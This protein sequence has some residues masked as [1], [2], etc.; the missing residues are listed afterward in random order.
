MSTAAALDLRVD[1]AVI[2]QESNR[3][4]V[5]L[6]PCDVLARVA[7]ASQRAVAELEVD[8][9]RLL[10]T[11]G[12][13]VALLDPRVE[14]RAY[15]RD[16]FVVTLW[17][18]YEPASSGAVAPAEYAR[19]LRKV[20]T[21]M[22][23]L[24]LPVPHCTD[25]V[26]TAREL[27]EDRDRTPDL[28]D[29]DR[30]LLAGTLATL[31]R[32]IGPGSGAQQLLHGEPHPG[33]V[34]RTEAGLLFVDLETCCRGPVEFDVAHVPDE[35][36]ACYPG[37]DPDLLGRCRL[38]VHAMVAAWRW[39]REDRFPDGRRMGIECLRQLRERRDRGGAEWIV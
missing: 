27:V 33:N 1:E 24:D 28:G 21:S 22:A 8:I 25:R 35:V 34:L 37:T 17:T 6:R 13:P 14:P 38:L 30:E 31:G 18:F 11:T 16:G 20:H 39:D 9:A 26:A 15:V 5:H 23:G 3:I 36:S 19:A 2:V 12:S 10:A 29:A 4:A 7:T 32:S